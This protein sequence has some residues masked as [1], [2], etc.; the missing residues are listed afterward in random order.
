MAT[1][2][3]KNPLFKVN[4]KGRYGQLQRHV[5]VHFERNR[6]NLTSYIQHPFNGF[7]EETG[8]IVKPCCSF[9]NTMERGHEIYLK[10]LAVYFVNQQIYKQEK[11]VTELWKE[12]KEFSVSF[13]LCQ[14]PG[15][16]GVCLRPYVTASEQ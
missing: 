4:K 9:V 14:A 2:V 12:V 3:L 13:S 16:A 11:K 10:H 6:A 8:W 7:R 5:T 1:L 15:K